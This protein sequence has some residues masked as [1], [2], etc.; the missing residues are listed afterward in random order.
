MIV[1]FFTRK[2]RYVNE[3]FSKHAARPGQIE[4]ATLGGWIW[5]DVSTADEPAYSSFDALVRQADN[6]QVQ[7][8]L[9]E[10]IQQAWDESQRGVII[11]SDQFDRISPSTYYGYDAL[12]AVRNIV[13]TLGITT[14][15][16]AVALTARSPRLEHWG[17]VWS[18]HFHAGNYRDFVCSN[19]QADKRH[20]WLAST[21]NPLGLA[22]TYEEEGYNVIVIDA[23]GTD[24]AGMDI[25]HTLACS[26]L[27][28]VEC[29]DEGFVI[30]A[31]ERIPPMESFPIDDSLSSNQL[32]VLE[33]LFEVSCVDV[34]VKDE[35]AQYDVFLCAIFFV[36]RLQ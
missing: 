29:D 10:S 21:M 34:V 26:V 12:A 36:S 5:P 31:E 32:E 20:E 4:S 19:E 13:R 2:G 25:A 33:D 24:N 35:N 11:G 9:M 17:Q 27:R 7:T 18:E 28:G 1:R 14:N 15:D 30:G 23:E 22:N 6:T 16:V 3:F 8:S